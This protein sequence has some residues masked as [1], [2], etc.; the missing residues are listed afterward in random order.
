MVL[1]RLSRQVIEEAERENLGCRPCGLRDLSSRIFPHIRTLVVPRVGQ[2]IQSDFLEVVVEEAL[3]TVAEL[4]TDGRCSIA[5]KLY[6]DPF[7]IRI[8]YMWIDL[9]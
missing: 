3:K 9:P 5:C 8:K 2:W 4:E 1:S 6:A 7:S